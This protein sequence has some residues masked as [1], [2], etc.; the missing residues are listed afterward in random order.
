VVD[1]VIHVILATPNP[2]LAPE[3]TCSM[4]AP[5]FNPSVTVAEPKGVTP[6][7]PVDHPAKSLLLLAPVTFATPTTSIEASA[8]APP[9][10]QKYTASH[11]ALDVLQFQNTLSIVPPPPQ[12]APTPR[13]DEP[14]HSPPGQSS[15]S[16]PK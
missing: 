5:L 4:T 2:A 12:N 1:S 10:K 11:V 3:E 13:N 15:H 6:L 16:N 14:S 7:Q 8:I 9:P